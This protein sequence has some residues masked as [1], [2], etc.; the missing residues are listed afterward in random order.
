MTF[1]LPSGREI[2]IQGREPGPAARVIIRDFRFMRRVMAAGDIGFAEGFM[3][4]EWDTPGSDRRC[5]CPPA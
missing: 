1:V 3:A 4:G 5:W 2:P